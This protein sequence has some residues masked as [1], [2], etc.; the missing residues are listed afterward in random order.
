[1]LE[2]KIILNP[3][4]EIV[5]YGLVLEFT[6]IGIG[7]GYATK[8]FAKTDLDK[9]SIFEV[10]TNPPLPSRELGIAILDN[11]YASFA[12]KKLISIITEK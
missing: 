1:M 3:K 10:K 5:S 11:E 4:I 9:K 6:K 8:E 7:I 12:V 2:N